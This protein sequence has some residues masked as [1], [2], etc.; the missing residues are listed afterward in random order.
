MFM[1]NRALDVVHRCVWHSAA[2]EYLQPLLCCF[3]LQ[4]GF[5]EVVKDFSVLDAE[6]VGD[7]TRIGY[8]FRLLK[9]IAE[10]AI[11]AVVTAADG[12]VGIFCFVG[13]VGDYG[14]CEGVSFLILLAR[15]NRTHHVLCPIVHCRL[16]R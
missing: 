2:L 9:L 13:A 16:Y 3:C 10:N 14:C 7:E 1:V 6:R 15:F 11:E 12:N 8:P 4:F 5:D